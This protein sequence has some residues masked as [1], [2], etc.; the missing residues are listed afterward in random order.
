LFSSFK[1]KIAALTMEYSCHPDVMKLLGGR[2]QKKRTES[3]INGCLV[4]VPKNIRS[5]LVGQDRINLIQDATKGLQD[6]K[7]S[8]SYEGKTELDNVYAL[9]LRVRRFREECQR[10][11][12]SDVF[13]ILPFLDGGDL[14]KD[15]QPKNLF[16][17]YKDITFENVKKSTRLYYEHGQENYL[18]ENL[19]WSGEA[20][21]NSC[22]SEMRDMILTKALFLPQK[23]VGGPIYFKL[24]MEIYKDKK[25]TPPASPS[26]ST[27]PR[28]SSRKA[29]RRLSPTLSLLNLGR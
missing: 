4:S 12:M 19:V 26:S 15:T 29:V 10:H 13:E 3:E 8:I 5:T 23:E 20:L 1:R 21:L 14:A 25:S 2:R 27:S 7:F 22:D 28:P 16:D 17:N 24:M 18:V 11:D 6:Y 9:A